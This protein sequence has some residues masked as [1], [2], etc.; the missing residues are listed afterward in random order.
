MILSLLIAAI[1]TTVMADSNPF[2]TFEKSM[3]GKSSITAV[4]TTIVFEDGVM[5]ATNGDEKVEIDISA[6]SRM[7]FTESRAILK[8]DINEDG[9]VN[10]V[11]VTTAIGY[12]LNK[13]SGTFNIYNADAQPDNYINMSDVTAIINIILNIP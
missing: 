2:L 3:G 7:Y 13:P 4:G 5:K 12:I 1:T 8:G 11:D 10:M 6:L 9:L